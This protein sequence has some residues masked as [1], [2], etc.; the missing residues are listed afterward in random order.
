MVS[1][2]ISN[3]LFNVLWICCAFEDSYSRHN[4]ILPK[5]IKMRRHLATVLRSVVYSQKLSFFT[6]APS[7]QYIRVVAVSYVV[8]IEAGN[9]A[10]LHYA[11]GDIFQSLVKTIV[12]TQNCLLLK[13]LTRNFSVFF[14]WCLC[15]WR[16]LRD[17]GVRL[18]ETIATDWAAIIA[19]YAKDII[20]D[21]WIMYW[22]PFLIAFIT[23][24]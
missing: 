1:I 19:A 8:S 20:I 11:R 17:V 3:A 4:K 12:G 10:Q 9:T 6:H 7:Y 16:V 14:F 24:R 21:F 23:G 15:N 18:I 13:N 22:A 2:L 5:T